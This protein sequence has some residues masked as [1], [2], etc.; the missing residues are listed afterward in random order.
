VPTQFLVQT[1]I[2]VSS[3]SGRRWDQVRGINAQG[4]LSLSTF[5]VLD[6]SHAWLL[7]FDSG[8]WRTT[9]GVR[10]QRVGPLHVY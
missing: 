2:T 1:H 4:A 9:D 5:D 10:W 6:A 8:L 7:G 3:D